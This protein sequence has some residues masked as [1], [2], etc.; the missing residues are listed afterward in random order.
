L[1]YS[2]YD[3]NGYRFRTT[4]LEANRPLVATT[5]S[6]VVTSGEY[7]TGHVTNYYGILQNIVEYTFGG[8]KEL[9]VVFLQCDWFDSINGTRVDDFSMVEVK[10]K[11]RYSGSNLLPTHQA[12]Q[13][14]YLSYPHPSLKNWWAVYKVNPKMHT[15]RYDEYVEGH[16]DDDIYQEEIEVDQNFM[17]SDG[18]GLAK[19]DTGDVQLL[20]EEAG[21]SNK[22]IQK[23]KRLL[24]RQERRERIDARVMEANSDADDF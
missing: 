9:K 2:R 6:G 14:Y 10:H 24:E 12:Q 18:A 23:S 21:P 4:K 8:T 11:L 15:R 1:E 7:V 5:N 16:K 17:V 20:D 3:I 22:R 19:L 13:V